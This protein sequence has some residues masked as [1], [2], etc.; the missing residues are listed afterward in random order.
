[1]IK[2]V[3]TDLDGTL[4][5]KGS[6]FN[7]EIYAIIDELKKRNILFCVS[8]GRQLLNATSHFKEG[9]DILFSS[10]N[11]AHIRLEN[12]E[13]FLVLKPEYVQEIMDI[14][15][16]HPNLYAI[17]EG[18]DGAYVEKNNSPEH[19]IKELKV[20]T[21]NIRFVEDLTKVGDICKITLG[22]FEGAEEFAQPYF[23][24]LKD[25]ME[26]Q[27]S[28]FYWLDF[29]QKDVNKGAGL[30]EIQKR[31]NIKPE[32]TVAFGD[33]LNDLEMLRNAEYSFAMANAHPEAKE[34]ANYVAPANVDDGV[35]V[36]LKK[37][38]KLKGEK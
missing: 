27:V 15:H 2:L 32:E 11:G 23:A 25:K 33:H 29:M 19:F 30:K 26:V 1:M 8:T 24:H 3:V 14:V 17:A 35:V 4:F 38:L 5:H 16:K 34:C 18:R 20:Y 37:L 7:E 28:G 36:V 21:S 13:I 31:F 22:C 9:Y 12:E 6:H 10:N